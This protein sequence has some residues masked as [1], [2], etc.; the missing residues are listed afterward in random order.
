MPLHQFVL[1]IVLTDMSEDWHSQ[2]GRG[3]RGRGGGKAG[4]VFV[5]LA[6]TSSWSP[7]TMARD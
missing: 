2:G 3:G 4:A 1:A 7:R 6:S 5:A